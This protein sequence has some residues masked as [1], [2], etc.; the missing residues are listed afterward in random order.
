MISPLWRLASLSKTSR[1]LLSR[2][3]IDLR[4]RDADSLNSWIDIRLP[5]LRPNDMESIRT[6]RLSMFTLH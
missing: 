5:A 4:R 2:S 1:C 6:A 3:D